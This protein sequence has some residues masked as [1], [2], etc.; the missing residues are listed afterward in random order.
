M[1][2][3]YISSVESGIFTFIST[4]RPSE[5]SDEATEVLFDE[6]ELHN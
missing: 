4:V 2:I 1:N 6:R 3:I 5:V